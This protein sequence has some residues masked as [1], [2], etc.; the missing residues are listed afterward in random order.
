[1]IINDLYNIA[2]QLNF[3]GFSQLTTPRNLKSFRAERLRGLPP[4]TPLMEPD[5]LSSG[6]RK[7]EFQI[8]TPDEML[9]RKKFGPAYIHIRPTNVGSSSGATQRCQLGELPEDGQEYG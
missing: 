8:S 3:N 1:M 7:K 9:V 6:Q 5:R 2:T 4:L